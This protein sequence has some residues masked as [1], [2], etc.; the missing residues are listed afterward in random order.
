MVFQQVVALLGMDERDDTVIAALK[1]LAG[2]GA[3][4]RVFVVHVVEGSADLDVET[5]A[6]ELARELEGVEVIGVL[7]FGRAVQEV[8]E[9]V[10]REDADLLLLGRTRAKDPRAPTRAMWGDHGLALLRQVDCPVLVVPDGAPLAFGEAVV[11]MDLSDS[12]MSAM[13]LTAAL[14]TRVRPIAIAEPG[15][16]GIQE[17]WRE[18]GGTGLL[19][20][21]AASS[22]ADA[23][24]AGSA[25]A[26]L[27]AIGSRGLTPMAAVLLGSTAERLGGRC[28]KPLLV[29]R[30]K[31][32]RKGLLG[33]LF[34]S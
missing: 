12:A 32:E 13:R 19:E 24:L 34:G 4:G 21:V 23:L 25:T 8:C 9:L 15:A 7:A 30:Q 17:G 10:E 28:E 29:Y 18:R 31:G 6:G 16:T 2:H 20:V 33:A 1:A 11:G 14:C 5:G 27:V 26:D 22:P 3:I